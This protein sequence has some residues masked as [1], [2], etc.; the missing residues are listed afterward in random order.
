MFRGYYDEGYF[1]LFVIY[2]IVNCVSS[3]QLFFGKFFGKLYFDFDYFNLILRRINIK[4][5]SKLIS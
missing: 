1:I 2:I 4:L 5:E 3:K